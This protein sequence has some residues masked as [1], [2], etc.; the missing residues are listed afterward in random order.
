MTTLREKKKQKSYQTIYQTA[1]SLFE[2][3]GFDKVSVAQIVKESGI[4][5]G[6]FFN[7]FPNKPDI[8]AQWFEENM[9][10]AIEQPIPDD[11]S[12]QNKILFLA[13]NIL[14]AA[15]KQPNLWQAKNAYAGQSV[16]IQQVEQRVDQTIQSKIE[17]FIKQTSINQ[18]AKAK[19]LAELIVTLMTG[20]II[21]ANRRGQSDDAM[22]LIEHKLS[23]LL[24]LAEG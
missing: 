19:I 23:I 18:S 15:Q 6:T 11:T 12:L 2:E 4:A 17:Y 10:K 21:E 3:H 20:T 7:Y 1:L 16:S 14:E 22:T 5:K 8:I 24:S 13:K 9:S